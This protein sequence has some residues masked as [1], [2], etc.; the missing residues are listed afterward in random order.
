MNKLIQDLIKKGIGNFM[1]RSR[2][3][4]AWKEEILSDMTSKMKMNWHSIMKTLT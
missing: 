3:A 4:L 2:D 1:D